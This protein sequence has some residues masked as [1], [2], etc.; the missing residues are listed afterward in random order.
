[1]GELRDGERSGNASSGWWSH[2]AAPQPLAPDDTIVSCREIARHVI[3]AGSI[4]IDHVVG[5]T[6]DQVQAI[7]PAHGQT[8]PRPRGAVERDAG[9]NACVAADSKETQVAAR[10]RPSRL[11]RGVQREESPP[12]ATRPI[13]PATSAIQ[14]EDMPS[15]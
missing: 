11:V 6:L 10:D 5:S 8:V 1:M 15:R 13:A 2:S 14:S 4:G 3:Q 9:G 12:A 7:Q